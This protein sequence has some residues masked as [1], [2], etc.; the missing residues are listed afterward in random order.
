LLGTAIACLVILLSRKQKVDNFVLGTVLAFAAFL[1]ACGFWYLRVYMVMGNP[2]YPYFSNAGSGVEYS[3]GG[4][5]VSVLNFILL[6]WNL[7]IHATS[8]GNRSDQIGPV[9][10]LLLPLTIWA[11]IKIKQARYYLMM[12]FGSIIL[13]FFLA[14]RSRFL[15]PILP[16]YFVS[17]VLGFELIRNKYLKFGIALRGFFFLVLLAGI[18]LSAYH[19][20]YQMK[21]F[22]G[23]W[24]QAD[25]RQHLERSQV[26]TDY[27]NQELP[28][29]VK[30][31]NAE[32]IHRFYFDRPIVR[33][34]LFAEETRYYE[35]F[36]TPKEVVGFFKENGFTHVLFSE[37]IGTSRRIEGFRIKAILNNESYANQYF[38]KIFESDS[39]NERDQKYHYIL[40]RI[41]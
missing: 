20:R 11:A 10:S 3:V 21:L 36:K 19:Y 22:V 2:L 41:R 6:P 15:Y 7:V 35:R 12:A 16:L 14:E 23:V 8:F 25:F 38:E 33:E 9:F 40:Y 29:D 34:G 37:P 1:L 17:G 31:L 13:W 4:R 39:L 18:A 32:E 30:I 27:V 26:I 5:G 24:D 28:E